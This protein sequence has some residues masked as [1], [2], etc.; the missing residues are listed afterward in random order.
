MPTQEYRN[1]K[2]ERIPGNTTVIG[3]NLGWKTPGLM[4]WQKKL[5]KAQMCQDCLAKYVDPYDIRDEAA[6]AGT[7]GHALIEWEIKRHLDLNF[8]K[9]PDPS[10]LR[11][12]EKGETAYLNYM[13]WAQQTNVTPITMEVPCVSEILQTGT[14]I[15]IIAFVANK[16]SIVEC[17]TSND[18]YED[19]LIQVAMQ[20]FAWEE[21]HPDEPIEG[22]HLLKVG[23]D[24]AT[25]THHYWHV[26]PLGLE[27]FKHLRALHDLKKE[28]KKLV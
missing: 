8:P 24:E 6:D 27:A 21:T 26:L 25:F 5:L 14:T 23:K 28:L 18:V 15:D 11:I 4:G 13:E 2:G 7:Y 12:K 16:R 22:L 17:K 19:F 10:N 9:P 1:A 20:K 3:S